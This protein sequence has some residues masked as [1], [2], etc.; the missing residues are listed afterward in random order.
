[1]SAPAIRFKR[2]DE[3]GSFILFCG[4]RLLLCYGTWK[5][6]LGIV[7]TAVWNFLNFESVW[8]NIS[9]EKHA[10]HRF[11]METGYSFI[12]LQAKHLV[13]GEWNRNATDILRI[14]RK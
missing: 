5:F 13:L 2:A 3:S 12:G 1:M 14:Y 9:L 8:S 4:A 10:I 6:L 11:S 7:S